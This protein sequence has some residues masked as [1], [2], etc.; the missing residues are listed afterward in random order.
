MLSFRITAYAALSV[1]TYMIAYE[2]APRHSSI[3]LLSQQGLSYSKL[4]HIMSKIHL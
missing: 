2:Q 1:N 4:Y 3:C